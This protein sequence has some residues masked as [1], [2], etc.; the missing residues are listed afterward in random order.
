MHLLGGRCACCR[1][2]DG[3]NQA[4]PLPRL[5]TACAIT[6]PPSPKPHHL[7]P[8]THCPAAVQDLA[9]PGDF[10]GAG[11]EVQRLVLLGVFYALNWYRELVN[12]FAAQLD[13]M[14]NG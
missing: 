9:I 13:L 12:A 10:G 11:A 4:K 3:A 6:E 8:T 14:D 7:P 2:G 1:S 5:R